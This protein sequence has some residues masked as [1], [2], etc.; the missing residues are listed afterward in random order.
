MDRQPVGSRT[1]A[2]EGRGGREPREDREDR[3]CKPSSAL[4]KA[5]ESDK[6]KIEQ[7][8]ILVK[9]ADP[10][11]REALLEEIAINQGSVQIPN[12]QLLFLKYSDISYRGSNNEDRNATSS[13]SQLSKV[14]NNIR[15]DEAEEFDQ[16]LSADMLDTSPFVSVDEQGHIGIF[17]PSSGFHNNT[18]TSQKLGSSPQGVRSELIANAVIQRQKEYEL[19][20]HGD[21]DG[22]PAELA[23]HLLD[24]HWNRQ[25]HSFLLTYRPAFTKDLMNG[26]PYYSRFLLN[27]IFAAAAKYS[28]RVEL[29]DDPADPRTAGDSYLRRCKQLL[30]EDLIFEQSTIPTIVGLL[31]LGS[32]CVSRGEI[33]KGWIYTG[34][35]TRMAYDLGLHLDVQKPSLRPED[36]EIRRRVFWG[37]FISDKLQSLYMGRPVSIQLR[38]SQVSIELL[39]TMEELE[40]WSPYVD[41][42]LPTATQGSFEPI[43]I[44]SISTFQQLCLLSK[45]MT[46]IINRFYFIGAQA[47]DAQASL[48]VLDRAL[49]SWY[50][51]LP[52]SLTFQPWSSDWSIASK[53][54]TPNIMI[55]HNGHLRSKSPPAD[56][57][58]TCSMAASN[59]TSVISRWKEIYTL[60][61][62]PYLIGYTAY[63]AC[64]IHV[65]NAALQAGEKSHIMLLTT[66]GMLKEL[67]TTNPGLQGTEKL[68]RNLMRVNGVGE[69]PAPSPSRSVDTLFTL[70]VGAIVRMF[71]DPLAQSQSQD[72]YIDPQLQSRHDAGGSSAHGYNAN[73]PALFEQMANESGWNDFLTGF[74]TATTDADMHLQPYPE[75]VE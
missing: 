56:S 60:R 61:R 45:L 43:P 71:P 53:A 7:L 55:L 44:Y 14:S 16:D 66:L 65:R 41:T 17:G 38:D 33:S 50:K 15:K 27:A 63:V 36:M 12:D 21:F 30:T 10:E 35:A 3:A 19:M 9:N 58:K 2:M 57:W 47:S 52:S 31:L 13:T 67:T 8:L 18:N 5:I 6:K 20:R 1:S 75:A 74:W 24:I 46:R 39:D 49:V 32:A 69:I 40:L 34:L 48:Q 68:I 42:K 22:V 29:R 28:D 62:A 51:N 25:H 23:I 4:I 73:N 37:T 54:V 11:R 72:Q 64:T 70:D 26:G 59:I